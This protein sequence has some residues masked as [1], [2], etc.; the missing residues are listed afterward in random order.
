MRRFNGWS[1]PCCEG[2]Q[3]DCVLAYLDDIIVIGESV[4]ECRRNLAGVLERIRKANLKLKPSKCEL[5]RTEISYLGHIVS[6]NGVATDPR[7]IKAVQNWALPLYVTDVRGFL[8]FCNYYRR[9]IRDYITLTRPLNGLLCK[10]SDRV[11]RAHHTRAFKALKEAL[12]SASLPALPRDG[13]PFYLDTDASAYGIGG[14]LSQ[15]QT[16][17]AGVREERPIA[18]HGRLLLPR[19]MRYCVRRRLNC[20]PLWRWFSSS[21]ATC[22]AY[23]SKSGPTTIHS[24]A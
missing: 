17:D 16:T 19:E 2:V 10:D 14:M 18:Y 20:W 23:A 6:A 9:F 22:R 4:G 13:D 11:W 8:G 21:D 5:F 7:K 3:Y 24:R 12:T 15:V 1:T